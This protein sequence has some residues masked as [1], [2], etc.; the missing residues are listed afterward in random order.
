MFKNILVPHDGSDLS[1]RGL[2]K[3]VQLAK[4]LGAQVTGFHVAPDIAASVRA[5]LPEAVYIADDYDEQAAVT[6]REHLQQ[7]EQACAAAGVKCSTSYEVSEFVADAI[8]K[9]AQDHQCDL[10]AI[11]SHGRTGLARVMLGSETQKVLAHANIPV[12][13]MR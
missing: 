1:R 11:A 2:E 13:V 5:Y 7:I 4:S 8:V 12:L 9:A 10:I 3:A 6:A